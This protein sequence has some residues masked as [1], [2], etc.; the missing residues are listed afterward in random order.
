ANPA[1]FD[2]PFHKIEDSTGEHLGARFVCIVHSLERANLGEGA[3]LL[4]HWRN[5]SARLP[6]GGPGAASWVHV[7]P[8]PDHDGYCYAGSVM[9][10]AAHGSGKRQLSRAIQ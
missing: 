5:W 10:Q 3:P 2:R 8:H 9:E 6:K 7:I 1:L 4:E